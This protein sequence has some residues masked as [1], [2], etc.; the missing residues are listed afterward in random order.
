MGS[1]VSGSLRLADTAHKTLIMPEDRLQGYRGVQVHQLHLHQLPQQGQALAEALDLRMRTRHHGGPTN[2]AARHMKNSG[3][4]L[5][6]TIIILPVQLLLLL[7]PPQSNN[8]NN[9]SILHGLVEF[10]Q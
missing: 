3:C 10:L 6:F 2:M 1:K 8:N 9:N 4:A 7:G 5:S